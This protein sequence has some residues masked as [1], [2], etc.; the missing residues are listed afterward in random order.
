MDKFV[1]QGRR[2]LSGK[3]A[4]GG[5]KNAALPIMAATLLSSRSHLLLNIPTLGD[6]TTIGRLL[7]RLGATVQY[8]KEGLSICVTSI[9]HCEAPYDL[10]KTMR[11]SVL[12]LGPLLARCGEAHLSLP[13]GCTI[14]SR[15]INLHLEALKKMGAEISI[16]HGVVHAKARRLHGADIHFDIPTVTGTE[17]IMMAATGAR[18]TTLL[19]NAACE[20]EVVDLATFLTTL[21]FRIEGAGTPQIRIEGIGHEPDRDTAY[22]IIPDRIEAG[23]YMA[24]AMITRGDIYLSTCHPSHL[25][26]ICGALRE[27]GATITEE[28]DGI[29]VQGGKIHPVRVTT[30]PHPGFPTDMQA[31]LMAVLALSSGMSVVT[32]TVFDGR[33]NHI[34]E[35]ARMGADIT[36]HG[37]DTTIRG[38]P[39]LSGAPVMASDLR[40]GA[41][42]VLAGLAA[43]DLTH[44]SRVYH[45]DRG[46]E[47]M[48]A[49]LSGVG[50][51]I[52]RISGAV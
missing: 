40:G 47:K 52:E 43:E 25:V 14:G 32:E 18:G 23:T 42:L 27:A 13:G 35:L 4:I 30:R 45:I 24:A 3:I 33:L 1:I 29:R 12:V 22:V 41:A 19:T 51:S 11:A 9:E 44:V 16:N 49:K 15:P 21:G 46:Y 34:A 7:Q 8:T 17:N 36:H 20:P 6:T 2:R 31:Q 10:V 38:V 28:N 37:Q 5:A 26:S 50:A 39:R 48:E